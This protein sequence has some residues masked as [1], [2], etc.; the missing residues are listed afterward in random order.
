MNNPFAFGIVVEGESFCNRAT[1]LD[2]MLKYCLT[3]QNVL[4]YSHRRTG[5]TSLMHQVFNVLERENPS[6]RKLHIDL[7]GVLTENQFVSNIFKSFSQI[8]SKIE[9]LVEL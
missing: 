6:I 7:Y 1:E 2:D 4:I 3:S 9:K 8:E 5:K